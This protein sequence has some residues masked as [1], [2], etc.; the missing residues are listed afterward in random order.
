[1]SSR[2]AGSANGALSAAV[3]FKRVVNGILRCRAVDVEA[4]SALMVPLGLGWKDREPP[5]EVGRL[6]GLSHAALA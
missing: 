5:R 3:A 1:M 2:V 4:L 6:F